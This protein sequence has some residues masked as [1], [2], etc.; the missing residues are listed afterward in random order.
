MASLTSLQALTFRLQQQLCPPCLILG[1]WMLMGFATQRRTDFS[2]KLKNV[3]APQYK[4]RLVQTH[5]WED[6]H[7]SLNYDLE[8]PIFLRLG[9]W[10]PNKYWVSNIFFSLFF[11]RIN[12]KFN[13]Y[14]ALLLY[15]FNPHTSN[16]A[17]IQLSW[18]FLEASFNHLLILG[19]GVCG[20]C[21][22]TLQWYL[23]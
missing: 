10:T 23:L 16:S 18:V 19:Q 13:A 14:S 8:A 21:G 9:A 2:L 22:L 12:P 15:F 3:L 5:L 11:K 4:S 20:K 6:L 1:E 7:P 17:T